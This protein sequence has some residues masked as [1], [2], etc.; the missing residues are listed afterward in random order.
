MGLQKDR[1]DRAGET[2]PDGAI[3]CYCD[4][5]G[6]PTLSLVKNCRVEND[7]TITP[8]TV[9]VRG[10][11]DTFFSIPAACRVRGKT[12]TGYLTTNDGQFVFRKHTEELSQ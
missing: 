4:W 2:Q 12:V 5:M 3:P 6:G 11:P 7:E 8:R 1:N 9:Y 10:E